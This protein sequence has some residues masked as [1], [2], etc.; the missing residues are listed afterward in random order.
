MASFFRAAGGGGGSDS[1]PR[2]EINS[3][4]EALQA[5]GLEQGS[6]MSAVTKAFRQRAK[7]LHP[8]VREGDRTSE[9]ELRRIIEAYQYLKE[10]ISFSST[11]PPPER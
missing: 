4:H 8:D 1:A 2:G 3:T 10:T 6:S 5:L 11:E 9:P 7:T